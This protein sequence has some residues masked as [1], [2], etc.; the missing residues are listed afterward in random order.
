[1]PPVHSHNTP[2]D[3]FHRAYRGGCTPRP[4]ESAFQVVVNETDLFITCCETALPDLPRLARDTVQDLRRILEAWIIRYPA[5][6]ESYN[7][8]LLP[9]GI[10]APPLVRTMSRA[11]A[12]AG[13]G[14]FAAVA[15]AIAHATADVLHRYSDDIIVENGGDL[16]LYSRSDRVVGLLAH[17][18]EGI[19]L[20]V[21]VEGTKNAQTPVCVCA[22][23]ATIGHSTSFGKG[24][25]AV[26]RAT[27][28]ALADA[29]AT[30]FCNSLHC[31]EDVKPLLKKA[32]H[33]KGIDGI[34]LQCGEALGLWGAVELVAV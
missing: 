29:H 21:L 13:V 5:F 7:P 1:M 19:T 31:P 23:S 4:G 26:I 27:D 30:A 20:G 24:E 10:L 6:R 33:T 22:S 16:C 32:Q 28:G 15:G 3:K 2:Y 17:P 8:V 11:A 25:L 34:F 14:P 12:Q 18:D 9:R